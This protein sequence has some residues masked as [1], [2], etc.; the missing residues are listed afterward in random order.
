MKKF[1]VFPILLFFLILIISQN[2]YSLC[3]KNQININ[4]ASKEELDNLYGIGPVKAQ[5]IIDSRVF[6]YVDDLIKVNG[7]GNVT[8]NKIKE[9]GLACVADEINSSFENKNIEEAK[10]NIINES[11]TILKE[12][13]GYGSNNIKET[14]Q[15]NKEE[16]KITNNAKINKKQDEVS[17]I[18]LTPKVIKT[19]KN[20]KIS[21]KNRYA[22]YGFVIFSILLVFLFLLKRKKFKNEFN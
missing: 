7:I 18:R 10:T 19:E 11:E 12:N 20:I 21:D 5:A 9:Q 3:E 6:N 17:I 8:L 14:A 1:I 2:V 16:T 4:N 22:I 15:K 13:N